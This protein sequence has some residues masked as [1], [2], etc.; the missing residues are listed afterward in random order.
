MKLFINHTNHISSRWGEDQ[1]NAAKQYGEIK[2][3][4]FPAIDP[5]LDEEEVNTLAGFN[6]EKIFKLEPEAVL[7]QGEYT[8]T[9]KLVELL[10]EAGITVLS[11]CSERVAKEIVEEDGSI[12]R[13]SSFRFV[14]FRK[15]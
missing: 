6:A 10:K 13:E 12:R 5:K 14:R 4:P 3:M 2:D 11:A 1:L 8:Y 9:F 7:C 15:Y